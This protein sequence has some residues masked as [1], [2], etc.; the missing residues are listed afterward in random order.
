MEET[1]HRRILGGDLANLSI[2]Q[3]DILISPLQMAQAIAALANGGTLYQARIVKQVQTLNNEVVYAY[4][5][6]ARDVFKLSPVT[7]EQLRKGMVAVVSDGTGGAADLK[8]VKVAGK[9]GTAEWGPKKKERTAAWF[10]GFAPADAPRYAF[11]ALYEGAPGEFAHGGTVAAPMI[12]DLL[13]ELF[14]DEPPQK[15]SSKEDE[16]DESDDNS[17]R[18][19]D[20]SN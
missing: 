14:K 5:P 16:S 18:T 3:G 15:K 9:T 8:N 11:A 2:G 20:Q 10:T 19:D 7:M 12:G 17:S 6:R 13:R 1:Y 4:S